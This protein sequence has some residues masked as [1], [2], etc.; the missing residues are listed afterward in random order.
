MLALAYTPPGV[1]PSG[2]AVAPRSE[3]NVTSSCKCRDPCRRRFGGACS[4]AARRVPLA[5]RSTCGKSP[6]TL[7]PVCWPALLA[8]AGLRGGREPPVALLRPPQALTLP[9]G[10]V[11]VSRT[12]PASWQPLIPAPEYCPAACHWMLVSPACC[13]ARTCLVVN[14]EH[15]AGQRGA[16]GAPAGT[17]AAGWVP[18]GV[19]QARVPLDAPADAGLSDTSSGQPLMGTTE[20]WPPGRVH[21]RRCQ[22][23]KRSSRQLWPARAQPAWTLR[24]RRLWCARCS[25]CSTALLA[26]ACRVAAPPRLRCRWVGRRGGQMA[27]QVFRCGQAGCAGVLARAPGERQWLSLFGL[28]ALLLLEV[29]AGLLSAPHRWAV[30]SRWPAWATRGACWTQ[31]PLARLHGCSSAGTMSSR[32]TRWSGSGWRR[33]GATW[34]LAAWMDAGPPPRPAA[35]TGCCA[36]GRVR[37]RAS[38]AGGAR[39]GGQTLHSRGLPHGACRKPPTRRSW[40]ECGEKLASYV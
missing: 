15:D 12:L 6:H 17:V 13:A 11:D 35:A 33:R 21:L 31:G 32:Q 28:P 20:P 34:R 30:W 26:P 10:V 25:T 18:A 36:C 19:C 14:T 2:R 16:P 39:A 5:C 27:G 3:S 7:H 22:A 37:A 40:L 29:T 24:C 4:L 8:P 1:L 9:A 38:G 23:W